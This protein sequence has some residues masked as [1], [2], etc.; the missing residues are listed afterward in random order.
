MRRPVSP[1]PDQV[2]AARNRIVPALSGAEDFPLA[3]FDGYFWERP[4]RRR[5]DYLTVGRVKDGAVTRARELPAPKS[6]GAL[7]VGT[8]RREGGEV[9]TVEVNQHSRLP[10]SLELYSRSRRNVGGTGDGVS[11]AGSLL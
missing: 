5:V 9:P 2:R 1:Q 7:L 10:R 6:D 4:L 8:D 11:A 3:Y